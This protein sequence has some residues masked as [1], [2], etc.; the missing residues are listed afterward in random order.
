MTTTTRGGLPAVTEAGFQEAVLELAE[1]RGW[2]FVH[3]RPARTAKGW[4]TPMVGAPGFPDVVLIRPPRLLVV[5]L[6]S[7]RGRATDD[8]RVWLSLL[9]L[10]GIDARLWRPTDWDEIA[11]ALR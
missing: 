5:E 4:R 8:Q 11:E 2:R 1:L 3:F 10:C 7:E 6:K 9:Q